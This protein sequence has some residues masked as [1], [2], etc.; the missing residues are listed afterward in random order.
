MVKCTAV[1][2]GS[3]VKGVNSSTNIWFVTKCTD[4]Q[5]DDV[6]CRTITPRWTDTNAVD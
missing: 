1:L 4:E 2:I 3:D 5:I 6:I